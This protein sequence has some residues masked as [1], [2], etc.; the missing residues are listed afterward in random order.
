M[1]HKP[2]NIKAKTAQKFANGL[3]ER[4]QKPAKVF[5]SRDLETRLSQYVQSEMAAARC[6]SDESLRAKAR[7]IMN[8]DQTSADDPELL[9]KFKEMHNITANTTHLG[10]SLPIIDDA[11]LAEFDHELNTM[12]LSL[13]TVDFAGSSYSNST[14]NSNSSGSSPD[15]SLLDKTPEQGKGSKGTG[16]Q[17]QRS[18]GDGPAFDYAELYRVHAATA[19]P[20]RRRASANATHGR[21]GP[22]EG[23]FAPVALRMGIS[24]PRTTTALSENVAA[25]SRLEGLGEAN[26]FLS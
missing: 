2:F 11:L 18:K 19:S 26:E 14:S 20:L 10:D 24:P 17:V 12:D 15:L 4:W 8:M 5:C 21:C 22:A 23:C 7:E 13:T 9:Q 6:P 16:T 25:V 3:M 1:K